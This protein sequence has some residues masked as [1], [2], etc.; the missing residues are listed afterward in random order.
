MEAH[1]YTNTDESI[2][3]HYADRFIHSNPLN[4]IC[5]REKRRGGAAEHNSIERESE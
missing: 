5:E 4:G 1:T 3:T 2:D